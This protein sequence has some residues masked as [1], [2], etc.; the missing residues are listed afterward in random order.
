VDLRRKKIEVA[1]VC[2]VAFAPGNLA[3]LVV[4]VP[5]S[6]Q[7]FAPVQNQTDSEFFFFGYGFHLTKGSLRDG[8]FGGGLFA[9]GN[10]DAIEVGKQITALETDVA[11]T[12][13]SA[14]VTDPA[15]LHLLA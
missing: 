13:W 5:A 8:V 9:G 11:S 14:L 6:E 4:G 2:D 12:K 7:D 1:T 3:G 10:G 15:A